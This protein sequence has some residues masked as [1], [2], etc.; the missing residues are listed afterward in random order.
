M[1]RDDT[2]GRDGGPEDGPILVVD[3]DPHLCEA[4]ANLLEHAGHR[5]LRAHDGAT[6]LALAREHA[7]GL[8][9]LDDRGPLMDGEAVLGELGRQLEPAP[10]ALLLSASSGPLA[11]V[12]AMGGVGLEKPFNARE[13]L[14]AVDLH[15]RRVSREAS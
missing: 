6:A 8:L 3:D 9:V 13:L 4:L 12:R 10:P 15:R 2:G 5:V 11:R 7:P 14:A 1:S